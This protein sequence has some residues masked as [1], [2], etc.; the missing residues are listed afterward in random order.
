MST[1]SLNRVFISHSLAALILALAFFAP[2]SSAAESDLWTT[3]TGSG[4]TAVGAP[5]TITAATTRDLEVTVLSVTPTTASQGNNVTITY[6]VRNNGTATASN[7]WTRLYFSTN[8]YIS[9][10]ARCFAA[11]SRM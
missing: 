3:H 11:P 4:P 2:E 6:R 5:I 10:F 7:F 1:N 9:Y 8:N